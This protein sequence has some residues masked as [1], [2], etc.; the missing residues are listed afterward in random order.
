[1]ALLLL[2]AMTLPAAA[3]RPA[4]RWLYVQ[5]NLLP[6]ESVARTVALLERAAGEGYNGVVLT[7]FKFM[8]WD[9]MPDTYRE[10]CRLMRETC[11]RLRLELVVGVMPI[12][13]S[14]SLLCRDPNLAEGLPVR[15]APFVVRQSRLVPDETLPF[16]NGGFEEFRGDEP[17]GWASVDSPGRM[18]FRD[19]VV[20]CEGRSSLRFQDVAR[21]EP[22]HRHARAWRRLKVAPFRYYRVSAKVR[23]RDWTGSDNRITVIGADGRVLTYHAPAI[24]RT[25]D[26][27][28]LDL[29]FNTLETGEVRLYVGTWGGE[30]G[31]IW[32]DDIRIEP[33]GFVN[34]LRRAGCP[35]AIRRD[36]DGMPC[37]E[38]RDVEAVADPLLGKDPWDGD[39]TAW[40]E[41]PLVRIPPGSRLREGQRVRADYY[42]PAIIHEGQMMCCMSDPAVEKI[43]RWQVEQV[44]DALRP[45]GY[46]MMHDEIRVQ[47]WDLSCEARRRSPADLLGDHVERCVAL[48]RAADPG[49]PIAV[50]SDMFDPC[51]NARASGFYYLVKGEGPWYGAWKRLP[52]D[53]TIV[54]WQMGARTRRD[55]LRHFAR[56]G[57]RQVLAGYYDGDPLMI[58]DWLRDARGVPG[59]E[60]VMYTTWR[61]NFDHTRAFLEAATP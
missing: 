38:G 32:W 7:D 12:G 8:L 20:K 50:W 29:C 57:H 3:D 47:G 37:V 5:A 18:A 25:Q 58:K 39:Y 61:G 40:H 44:R 35:L 4:R 22:D 56:R 48:I 36:G 53:V 27:R 21:H 41:P 33:A 19:E 15:D 1:M 30:G 49:K 54:N 23:T 14:N 52:A 43:L 24:E 11:R 17:S 46:F 45:D 60:G 55:T 28:R 59:V 13:Y 51:H 2:G 26:W 42:H 34:V 10:H 31:T 16:P 9:R 6:D